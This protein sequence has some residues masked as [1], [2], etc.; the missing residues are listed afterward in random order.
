MADELAFLRCLFAA[1]VAAADPRIVLP[2][3]L[4]PKPAGRCVIIGA[5]KAAAL[6]AQ[7]VDAAWADVKL[8]GVVVTRY[9][10][11]VPAGRIRVLEAGHPVPDDA[12]C[13][14]GQAIMDAV[15]GLS[16]A[17]L[18]I[19]LLSGGG[20]ALMVL[21][22]VGVTLQ[23]KQRV[24]RA[25]LASGATIAEIN[26][27]RCAL[28]AIKGG[29]LA[30][31]VGT[32]DLVTLAISDVP[33]DDPAIIASG[34]TH[35][36]GAR[37][38]ASKVLSRY[39]I[40]APP[41]TMWPTHAGA[42]CGKR[43][44]RLIATPGMALAASARMAMAAGVR[45]VILGD[46][47]EGESAQL[48]RICGAIALNY[49]RGAAKAKT[50]MVI[51]SGGETTVTLGSALAGRGGRNMEFLLSLARQ[52][53]G[54]DGIHA[55]AAD[56]DGI[57]G[58]EDAAGAVISPTTLSRATTRCLDPSAMLSAHDSYAFF[59]AL[60]DLVVTG[61]TFTNV[62]DFRAILIA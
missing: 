28:S 58:S 52:L 53:D 2:P 26:A 8:T 60:G 14:A 19:C 6:M 41:A 18:V 31:A 43:S 50:P 33:G 62:N 32:A 9:G 48:G 30:A 13:R 40:P 29:K 44:Y 17:D 34:P 1:A 59:S 24:T 57:D 15:Q 16:K 4:P 12:S 46:A 42:P 7:V 36:A 49:Q 51:L 47:L 54:V 56:T 38:P 37:E 20:S 11:A 3:A 23:D 25:L 45:P 61:P 10:H 35:E 27:V 22:A 39:G 21:P 55:L 5:G